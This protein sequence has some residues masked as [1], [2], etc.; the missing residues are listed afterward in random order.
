[1]LADAA[2]SGALGQLSVEILREGQFRDAI[3]DFI[4][5][6]LPRWRDRHDR[7]KKTRETELTTQLC[8]HLNSAT[9][10]N[11]GWDCC[12][13]LT[14]VAD[15]AEPSRTI[16]LVASPAIDKL[17]VLGRSFSSFETILPIEC[18]RLP[19]PTSSRR[20][21]REYVVSASGIRGGIQRFKSAKHGAQ[22]EH[23]A[24]I[25]YVQDHTFDY[26]LASIAG[27]IRD[28]QILGSPGWSEADALSLRYLDSRADCAMYDSVHSRV[29][30]AA[31]RIRHLWVKMTK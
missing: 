21:E 26:W 12:Q 25:A 9:R 6:E 11:P 28:L 2:P 30:L 16:D 15:E 3:L 17:I 18:K 13:F 19:T 31:I 24:L 1:M 20:D 23:G 5:A 8:A 7:P 29:N 27:W 22:H 4:F 10:K 14:E